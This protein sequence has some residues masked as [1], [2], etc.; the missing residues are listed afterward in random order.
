MK[1]RH[2]SKAQ[3]PAWIAAAALTISVSSVALAAGP[4][5]PAGRLS[6]AEALFPP[7]RHGDNND[8]LTKGLE[9]TVPPVDV[10]VDFHGSLDHPALVLYASGNYFFA[11]VPLV[12]AFEDAFPAYRGKVFFETLPPGLLLK[13]MAA[14]GTVTSGNMTFTVPPDVFM[15]EQRA[16][17]GLVK[18]GKLVEPIVSFATNDLTIMVPAGNPAHVAGLQ[19]LG[20]DE[21]PIVM[22]NPA[23]EG[24]AKQIRASLVKA[25]GEALAHAV[26]ET[27]V[28]Q[29]TAI[30]TRIH[31]RQ[32]PLF[33]MQGYGV[34][35]VTWK[36]EAI[37]QESLG[38]AITHVVIPPEQNTK[39]VYS[40]AMVA[41]APHAEAAKVWLGFIQSDQAFAAFEP[42]GFERYGQ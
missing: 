6:G 30:L 11:M 33:L 32:T 36:S 35:G 37:F 22:P 15:A 3:N 41:N 13:Q 34:A 23:F 16:S 18:D 39:A 20:R 38:H 8:A 7:W 26:Y 17:E 21:V 24:V 12:K 27:K 9:F 19:D 4:D 31:H 10:M 40:A 42:F 1:K 28:D 14:G 29:G 5:T 25:G 2:L